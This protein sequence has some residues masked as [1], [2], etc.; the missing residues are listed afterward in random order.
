MYFVLGGQPT[1][2]YGDIRYSSFATYPH[3]S[4]QDSSSH[5]DN[6]LI[7]KRTY[8]A[9]TRPTSPTVLSPRPGSPLL[10]AGQVPLMI[11]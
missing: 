9:P 10:N 7:A 2:R 8:A 5:C 4:G 3:L 11:P 6:P 1:W